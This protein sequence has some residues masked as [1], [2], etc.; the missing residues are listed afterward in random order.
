M[1]LTVGLLLATS[2]VLAQAFVA[3]SQC[4]PRRFATSHV[5]TWSP[6]KTIITRWLA[7]KD[8]DDDDD[9][10]DDDEHDMDESRGPLARGVDSVSWLPSAVGA[11]ARSDASLT[12]TEK[13][14]EII[15]LVGS[16]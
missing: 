5:S 6:P 16:Y 4:M 8:L 9:D 15:P 11:R 10:D 12:V 3:P 1:K 2:T 7:E 13:D 14:A